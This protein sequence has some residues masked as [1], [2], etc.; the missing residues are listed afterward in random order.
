MRL[1]G[2]SLHLF[3]C[4]YWRWSQ[5]TVV[6][7]TVFV[8]RAVCIFFWDWNYSV[9]SPFCPTLLLFQLLSCLPSALPFLWSLSPCLHCLFALFNHQTN[10]LWHAPIA[11]RHRCCQ[12]PQKATFRL[13]LLPLSSMQSQWQRQKTLHLPPV[14][15]NGFADCCSRPSPHL[16]ILLLAYILS[17][18]QPE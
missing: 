18:V 6:S 10:V 14:M 16:H 17:G 8:L 9:F 7:L 3:T 13:A 2:Q 5:V 15:I 11:H 4:H 1:P 12:Q